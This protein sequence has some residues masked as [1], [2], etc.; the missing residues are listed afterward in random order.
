MFNYSYVACLARS[1]YFSDTM[2]SL[3]L[4]KL[5]LVHL[6]LKWLD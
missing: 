3:F 1:S 2:Y 4:V 5:F 6:V